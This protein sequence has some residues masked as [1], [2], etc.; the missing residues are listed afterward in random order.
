MKEPILKIIYYSTVEQ[1]Y[2][3]SIIL[4]VLKLRKQNSS[5]GNAVKVLLSDIY[6]YDNDGKQKKINFSTTSISDKLIHRK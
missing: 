2:L 6:L 3:G 5:M 1:L 4:K